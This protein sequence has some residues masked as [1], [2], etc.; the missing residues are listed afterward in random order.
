MKFVSK[1]CPVEP[2]FSELIWSSFNPC[3]MYGIDH[4]HTLLFCLVL[5]TVHHLDIE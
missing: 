5:D 4:Y 3:P 1:Y 2:V